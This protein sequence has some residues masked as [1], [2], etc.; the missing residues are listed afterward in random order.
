[1]Q[2][3]ESSLDFNLRVFIPSPET[4]MVIRDRLNKRINREFEKHGIEIPFPQRDLHIKSSVV[5]T[6]DLTPD[7]GRAEIADRQTPAKVG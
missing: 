1:M 2:H 6:Q 7:Q 4:I 5:R 3:G